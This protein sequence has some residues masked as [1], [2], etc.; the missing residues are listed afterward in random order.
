MINI[1]E[2]CITFQTYARDTYCNDFKRENSEFEQALPLFK[3]VRTCEKNYIFIFIDNLM[4][5]KIILLSLSC[6]FLKTVSSNLLYLVY[7]FCVRV[8][9]NSFTNILKNDR[10]LSGFE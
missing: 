1:R 5:Q 10:I 6:T 3:K 9:S 8:F 2:T 7:I 4:I